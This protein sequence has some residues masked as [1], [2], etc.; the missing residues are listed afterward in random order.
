MLIFLLH[1]LL[2][3]TEI[4]NYFSCIRYYFRYLRENVNFLNYVMDNEDLPGLLK[5]LICET[6][7][8]FLSFYT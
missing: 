4:G 3:D 2:I 1:T 5:I 6:L 8:I 7:W